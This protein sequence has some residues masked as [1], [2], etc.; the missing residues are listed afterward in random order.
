[1]ALSV[2]SPSTAGVLG[3]EL[4]A[5]VVD[6]YQRY[7]ACLLK[8]AASMARNQ[9]EA[10]DAVQES[11]L[12]YF[13]QRRYGRHIENPR[14][15]LYQVLHNYLLDRLKSIAGKLE[16]VSS[17]LMQ[18]IADQNQNPEKLLQCRELATEIAAALTGRELH[19]LR[20]RAGGLGYEEIADAM[21]LR[22]GTVGSL[23]A[24]VHQK[25]R[26]SRNKWMAMGLA[27]T[28]CSFLVEGQANS[29]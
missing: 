19:C 6:L 20:L 18:G 4:E 12:R 3:H 15:W 17:D 2:P 29:S 10:H 27:D 1:M 25:L 7:S 28:V 11:Y 26:P 21:D 24:R 14:A 16:V 23:L 13:I 5:E 8:Y 22:L 9:E